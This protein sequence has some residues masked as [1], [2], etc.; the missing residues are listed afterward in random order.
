MTEETA[1]ATNMMAIMPAI[2]VSV[3]YIIVIVLSSIGAVHTAV[4]VPDALLLLP[5]D[6][7]LALE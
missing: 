2:R 6:P 4:A 5:G 7:A 3:A 1:V